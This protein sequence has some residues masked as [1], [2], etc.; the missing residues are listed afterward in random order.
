[1]CYYLCVLRWLMGPILALNCLKQILYFKFG[2]SV[3]KFGIQDLQVC[4]AH[5]QN[6]FEDEEKFTIFTSLKE[7]A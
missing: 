3:S 1:M 6:V 7:T 4:I 5:K 2:D